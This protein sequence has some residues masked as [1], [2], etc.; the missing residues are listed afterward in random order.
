MRKSTAVALCCFFVCL[1]A[2]ARLFVVQPAGLQLAAIAY[3]LF[4]IYVRSRGRSR[5]GSRIWEREE[6]PAMVL[7]CAVP[8]LPVFGTGALLLFGIIFCL[9]SL[10]T[11]KDIDISWAAWPIGLLTL[12]A[13][14]A[15]AT[16]LDPM[17]LRI[18]FD[19]TDGPGESGLANILEWI[20]VSPPHFLV[21]FEAAARYIVF[22][23]VFSILAREG[24]S[25]V[26]FLA[27]FCATLPAAAIAA[28]LAW[29]GVLPVSLPSQ[30]PYWNMQHRFAGTFTDP[31]A[32][33]VIM[34]L[35]IPLLYILAPRLS[36]WRRFLFVFLSVLCVASALLSGSRS[37]LLGAGLFVL[38]LLFTVNRRVFY[39]VSL[40]GVGAV[41][42]WNLAA[43]LVPGIDVSVGRLL[44]VAAERLVQTLSFTTWE[45]AL[46]SRSV[47]FETALRMWRD[48]PVF[49]VGFS[50]FRD[51]VPF[52]THETGAE[53]GM[54]VDNANNWYLQIL[55]ETGLIGAAAF[56]AAAMRLELKHV[57]SAMR[58]FLPVFL[59]VLLFGPHLEFDEVAI[60]AAVMLASIAMPRETLTR[61]GSDIG[62]DKR[63]PPWLQKVLDWN[64]SLLPAAAA[65]LVIGFAYFSDRGFFGIEREGSSFFR[66]TGR[67]AA[68]RLYCSDNGDAELSLK[69]LI[70]PSFN[71]S[72]T[73]LL[74]PENDPPIER[75]LSE[76]HAAPLSF[77]LQCKRGDNLVKYALTVSRPWT[78]RKFGMGA[79]SRLLG[80]RVTSMPPLV[81][82]VKSAK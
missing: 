59:V 43:W 42:L 66:W 9:T 71:G 44:P 7:G 14:T 21:T 18:L 50:M 81:G 79:D 46:F 11:V 22:F 57:P 80:V 45:R 60:F 6:W 2:A 36:G 64:Q 33:G 5:I 69:P 53:I 30:T 54:W 55:S 17:A 67:K 73:V 31:N 34:A 25:R 4:S 19:G 41:A 61:E 16:G 65:L 27:G 75:T 39:G 40:A 68:G 76:G 63:G 77:H 38:M 37:F 12:Y 52:Y 62:D 8:I 82:K 70:P 15:V 1:P 49:G 26:S 20:T 23:S 35:S 24:S 78:P 10:S 3:L 48:S 56:A 58:F 13:A 32:F 72:M 47:F 74:E 28:I 51:Y 29:L